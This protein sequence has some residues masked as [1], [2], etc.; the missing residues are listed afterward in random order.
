MR[1]KMV[2]VYPI[3]ILASGLKNSKF[4][5]YVKMDETKITIKSFNILKI[6]L[7]GPNI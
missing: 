1:C 5:K 3:R 6:E 4:K 2:Q 7:K